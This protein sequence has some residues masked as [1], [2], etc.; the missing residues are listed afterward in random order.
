MLTDAARGRA[1][2]VDSAELVGIVVQHMHRRQRCGAIG[3]SPGAVVLLS[4]LACS[5]R[6]A[7]TSQITCPGP[8]GSGA[9]RVCLLGG[10]ERRRA[11]TTCRQVS[12]NVA[13]GELGTRSRDSACRFGVA[14]H[15]RKP[16][17]GCERRC[18][19]RRRLWRRPAL[20]LDLIGRTARDDA[21]CRQQQYGPA[22]SHQNNCVDV[23]VITNPCSPTWHA[24]MPVVIDRAHRI[25]RDR[26]QFVHRW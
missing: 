16:V 5:L 9:R 2:V 22:R 23:G 1:L 7:V 24:V 20:G 19:A 21:G 11:S 18:R 3:R 4:A 6:L 13:P 12:G 8:A 25:A 17:D 10:R 15:V 26:I 14:R